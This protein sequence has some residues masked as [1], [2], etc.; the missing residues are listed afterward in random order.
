MTLPS[1]E[2]VDFAH[3][4][5]LYDTPL[6]SIICKSDGVVSVRVAYQYV[7]V[8][9]CIVTLVGCENR[10]LNGCTKGG[11]FHDRYFSFEHEGFS[12]RYE[13][14]KFITFW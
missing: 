6:E 13:G 7:L 1:Q 5:H 8:K 10:Y 9:T 12:Y 3:I 11:R 14:E 4:T 2:P